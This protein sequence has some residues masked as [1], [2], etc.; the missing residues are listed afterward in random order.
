[1]RRCLLV[2]VIA[3]A[4]AAAVGCDSDDASEPEP[5]PAPPPGITRS[6][7][8]QHLLA[9]Q[10]IADR[11]GGTR[12]AGTPGYD[13][14][15]DYVAARLRDAGWRVRRQ[16][17]PFT[18]FRLEDASVSV[19]GRKLRRERDFQVLSY[20]GSGRAAGTLHTIDGDGCSASDFQGVAGSDIPLVPRGGCLTHDKARNAQR[21][22]AHALVVFESVTS[23]RGV[24]SA[25]LVI[26]DI[27]IPVVGVAERAL[28]DSAT[29]VR[30]SVD[31]SSRRERTENVIAE[32]PGG[33]GDR[34][35]MAGGH[36][37]SVAG[38]PGINDNGSGVATLIEL[39]EAI[40]PKPPGARVRIGLWAAEELGLVG[41]RRYVGS[42]TGD[43]RGR[44]RAYL[45]F[46][47][48][49]SPNPVPELYGDA[50]AGL[51]E[52]L[53]DAAG[54][55]KLGEA[56]VTGA[57]DHA[58]FEQRGIPV[59]G[60]YTG[61]AEPAP[62]GGLRDPCYHLSCDTERDVN[63]GILVRMARITADAVETL[64]ERHK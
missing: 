47:M 1:V 53:R 22:G 3:A 35:V 6:E 18:H 10:R 32:T 62:G 34:I 29:T 23:P 2:L 48:V 50:D 4:A 45:N 16:S 26:P 33:S 61:A 52:L 19:A 27:R 8:D 60:L 28:G 11:S 7:L 38:G 12:A 24:P 42:L 43:E 36:L 58:P 44:I 51:A 20:S 13:A 9:L 63:L 55:T 59:N 57:S 15:A 40:G 31:A 21:A 25:T 64:S 39:A 54:R 56:Q 37:D 46:D 41:S 49:G 17:V 30:V 5:S 14:S